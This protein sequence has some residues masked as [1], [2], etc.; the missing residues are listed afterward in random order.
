[1]TYSHA[2]IRRQAA[3]LL[4]SAGVSREPVDL[5]QVVSALNLE[6]VARARAP[7]SGEAGLEP[8]GD[9]R[10]IVLSGAGGERRRRFTIAHEI[11]HFVLHPE[12]SLPERGGLVTEAGRAV[13]READAFAAELL[14]PEDLVREAALEHGAKVDRLADRFDVSRAAMRNRLQ[15]LGI[16]E[17]RAD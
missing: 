17:R 14:M 7:F 4:D 3:R 9:G 2:H 15:R 8:V 13:E 10:A 16:L 11:G 6:L 1:M 5:R 12:L